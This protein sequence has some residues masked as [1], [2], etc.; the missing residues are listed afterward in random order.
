MQATSVPNYLKGARI[1]RNGFTLIELLVVLAI[2]AILAGLLLP[3][4]ARAKAK[5]KGTQCM[6]NLK[7]ILL[8]SRLYADDYDDGLPPYGIAGVNPAT[9][10]VVK[11]GVNNTAD[12]GWPDTLLHYVGNNTNVYSCP[13]NPPG[14]F[15]NL[16]INLNLARSL[17]A[18]GGTPGSG[19]TTALL[20]SSSVARPS[21]TAYYADSGDVTAATASDQN[22]D[23][24]VQD[25]TAGQKSWIDWRSPYTAPNG[26]ADGNWT[27]LPRRIVN[28]HIGRAMIGYV[29][30]HA[31]NT[32]ASSVGFYQPMGSP[33]DMWSGQ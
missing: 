3:A 9:F 1:R 13:A 6:N 31:E 21:A 19:Y 29:D 14:L 28:R 33:G 5:A 24:W 23:N 4:L 32:K 27:S 18:Y 26:T 30:Y 7:E 22:A 8:A 20:K 10:I 15:W 11:G 25:T 12:E 17:W 2:I 16:G